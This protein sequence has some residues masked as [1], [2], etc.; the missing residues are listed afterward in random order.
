MVPRQRVAVIIM[1]KHT[2][3]EYLR[4]IAEAGDL[5]C[6]GTPSEEL[7]VSSPECLFDREETLALDECAFDLS[8]VYRWIDGVADILK[9]R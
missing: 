1:T 9:L 4:N 7:A 3:I 5:V 8:V 2:G 6:S